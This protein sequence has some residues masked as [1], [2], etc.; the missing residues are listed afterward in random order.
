MYSLG[1]DAMSTP[2]EQAYKSFF[3]ERMKGKV[4]PR[5]IFIDL[6]PTCIDQIKGGP[7]RDL[8]NHEFLLSDKEDSGSN[9]ARGHYRLGR[10]IIDECMNQIRRLS[11]DCEGLQGFLFFNSVG[12][13]TGSGLGALLLEHLSDEYGKMSK[14]NFS[15]YPSDRLS[16]TVIEP[17]NTLFT[18]N[19]ML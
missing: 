10:R 16:T 13:G 7:Y 5:S 3:S 15:I 4:I 8:F 9:F 14:L 19:Y 6:E 18:T 12:G 17:Y 2:S 11:D 1:D